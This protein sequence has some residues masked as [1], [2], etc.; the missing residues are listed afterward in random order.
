MPADVRGQRRMAGQPKADRIVT[1]MHIPL[2]ATKVCRTNLHCVPLLSANTGIFDNNAHR[3][4]SRGQQK[5]GKMSQF[6]LLDSHGRVRFCLLYHESLDLACLAS[7]LQA[8]GVG[9][10]SWYTLDHLMQ[11]IHHLHTTAYPSRGLLMSIP[12]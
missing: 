3:L 11:T 2:I 12:F 6:L 7:V 10:F 4:I 8:D 9:V 5:T 1:V